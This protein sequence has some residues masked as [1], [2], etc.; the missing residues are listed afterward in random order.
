MSERTTE[1]QLPFVLHSIGEAKRQGPIHR[2]AGF[3]AHQFIWVK[4][5]KGLFSICGESY[6]LEEGD[7]MFMRA[8]VPHSY[9]GDYLCTGWCTFRAHESLL[10]YTIKDKKFILFKV[11][12]FLE[13]ETKALQ[14]LAKSN[15]SNLSLSAAGYS[16]I[17]ELFSYITEPSKTDF[18]ATVNDYLYNN[19]NRSISLDDICVSLQAD[20]YYLCHKYKEIC[21][22]T[23][24]DKLLEIRIGKAK[25]MLRYT[26][27]S[28]DRIGY[29]CGFESSSYFCKRFR[30][31]T[32]MT[33][34]DY[35]RK[36]FG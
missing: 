21:G 19:Y 8:Y 30:E 26:A 36:R 18:E 14:E 24:M 23:V 2:D 15:S 34:M 12:D 16:Y 5:G 7:G 4:K 13:K 33:P 9:V 31:K 28:I 32:G 3:E 20:K 6:V 11:P 22:R 35:R 17:T 10:N 29:G 27:E 1:L 25:R